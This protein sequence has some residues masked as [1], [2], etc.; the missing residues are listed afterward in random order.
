MK[1]TKSD[2]SNKVDA[3][4]RLFHLTGAQDPRL[5]PAWPSQLGDIFSQFSLDEVQV[6]R[7][8]AEPHLE[9]AMHQCNLLIYEMIANKV[10]ANDVAKEIGRLVPQAAAETTQGAMFAFQRVTVVGQ[11]SN[12]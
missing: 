6:H 5:V 1:I 3:L 12:T 10:A 8:D 9:Y 4:E 2:P 7:V 11:K